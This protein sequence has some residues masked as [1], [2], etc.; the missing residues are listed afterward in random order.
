M[1]WCVV[2]M[3]SCVQGVVWLWC[4]EGVVWLWCSVIREVCKVR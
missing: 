2:V 4:V 3:V 1:V